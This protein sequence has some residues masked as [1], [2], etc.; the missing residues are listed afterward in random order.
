MKIKTVCSKT[1]NTMQLQR[2]AISGKVTL[3]QKVAHKNSLK[4][5][6]MF[7]LN[8]MVVK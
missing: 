1:Q 3:T 7:Y 5:V 2:I 6:K 4:T 8:F